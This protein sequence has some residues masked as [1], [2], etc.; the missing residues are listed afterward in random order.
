MGSKHSWARWVVI[1]AA[2]IFLSACKGGGG[3]D[4]GNNNTQ[5]PVDN[6][7]PPAEQP[8]EYSGKTGPVT[9]INK[10]A[11][12]KKAGIAIAEAGRGAMLLNDTENVQIPGLPI[13]A[14]VESNKNGKDEAIQAAINSGKLIAGLNV[15]EYATG[16]THPENGNCGGKA[17]A[18]GDPNSASSFE[19]TFDK[20][21]EKDK[22]DALDQGVT[23]DG[24]VKVTKSN[25]SKN[26]EEIQTTA[27][28]YLDVT[29][30]DNNTGESYTLD[31]K[32]SFSTNK[33]TGAFTT[34]FDSLKVTSSHGTYI[35]DSTLACVAGNCTVTQEF[36]GADG[37]TVYKTENFGF[38]ESDTVNDAYDF[39]GKVCEP[40][41]GCFNVAVTQAVTYCDNGFPSTGKVAVND[42]DGN[43]LASLTF[44][45]CD[46]TVITIDYNGQVTTVNWPPDASPAA[47][48]PTPADPTR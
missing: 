39:N 41:L 1:L 32:M 13:A 47:A 28:E 21:C 22:N 23:V 37:K 9:E 17:T 48:D 27:I 33:S 31:G 24:K 19:M 12:A 38:D 4:E 25:V 6:N 10:L 14:Q 18:N 29:S 16:A 46:P 11:D 26:G 7:N 34:E 45:G 44:S 8:V 40:S 5:P 43:E 36:M 20:Y 30:T 2:I 42:A 35:L 3:D 15:P